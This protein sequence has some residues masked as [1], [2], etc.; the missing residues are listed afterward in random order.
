MASVV[1]IAF[2]RGLIQSVL[3]CSSRRA[4]GSTAVMKNEDPLKMALL[5]D[6]PLKNLNDVLSPQQK[7][8]GLITVD[9]KVDIAITTGVPEEH[10][11]TRLVRIWKPVKHAMQ[12]GT[13]NTHKWKMEF[14]TRERWE[15][16][17]MGWT[18]T[19]DPLSNLQLDFSTK[20]EAIAFCEKH[21]YEY[22]VSEVVEKQ[23]RPKS[24]GANFSWN[25][26]TRTS[27]K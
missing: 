21:G 14:D 17:L 15:N 23:V 2:R 6:A 4:F 24:Y 12:S 9:S 3:T 20:E 18:S 5:K 8:E 10:I 1:N 27:T 25:K 26:K 19:G 13:N 22:S 11:K 16:P 7:H